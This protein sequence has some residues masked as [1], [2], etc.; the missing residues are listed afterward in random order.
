MEAKI[1]ILHDGLR[2]FPDCGSTE[3]L[4]VAF[5][6]ESNIVTEKS[7]KKI[8]TKVHHKV[9]N[10]VLILSSSRYVKLEA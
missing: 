5:H 1:Q 10:L 7:N 2:H 6:D 4:Q 3:A 8:Y 9:E